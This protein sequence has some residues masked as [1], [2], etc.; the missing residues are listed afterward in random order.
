VE[1]DEKTVVDGESLQEI[2]MLYEDEVV[3]HWNEDS[4]WKNIREL[5]TEDLEEN[6]EVLSYYRS[7]QNCHL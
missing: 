6:K 3:L 1:T 5:A 7:F 2:I 4:S